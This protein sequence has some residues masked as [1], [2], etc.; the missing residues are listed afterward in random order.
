MAHE[1]SCAGMPRSVAADGRA[2]FMI[3]ESRMIISWAI[4]TTP[5]INHRR[6]SWAAAARAASPCGES[7][8]SAVG[9]ADSDTTNSGGE[10]G[11]GVA[12][13][14]DQVAVHRVLPEIPHPGALSVHQR[15]PT[16]VK[17]FVFARSE[18]SQ[19]PLRHRSGLSTARNFGSLVVPE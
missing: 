3:A 6:R 9:R 14:E 19:A 12:G 10:K 15:M 17:E 13:G 1:M 8:A 18:F 16:A 11:G 5:R 7:T 2:M 4:A